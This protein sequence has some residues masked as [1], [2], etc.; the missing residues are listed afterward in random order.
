M[1]IKVEIQN[2]VSGIRYRSIFQNET[3]NGVTESDE[4]VRSKID[5]WK[6]RQEEKTTRGIGWG[7]CA[8]II[9]KDDYRDEYAPIL[10]EEFNEVDP[11]TG[12]AITYCRLDKE[13]AY[14]E[15]NLTS[16]Y[17]S[18]LA[19]AAE[20]A[21]TL[22]QLKQAVSI[23]DGWEQLSDININFLKKFFKYLI[24]KSI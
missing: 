3:I 2:L 8:R 23:I 11:M 13:Y 15:Y 12:E 19:E 6:A 10:I 7:W 16:E 22:Q 5:A 20:D 1:R 14:N 9:K 21:E 17:V 18:E 4:E 24:R